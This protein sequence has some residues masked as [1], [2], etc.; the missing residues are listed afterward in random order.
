MLEVVIFLIGPFG[1][2]KGTLSDPLSEDIDCSADENCKVAGE[3]APMVE[4][5]SRT[6]RIDIAETRRPRKLPITDLD[7]AAGMQLK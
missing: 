1:R 7:I 4:Y 5:C 3:T 6:T 2:G